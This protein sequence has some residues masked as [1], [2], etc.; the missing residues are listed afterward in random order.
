MMLFLVLAS[1][2][3]VILISGTAYYFWR[4]QKY[5]ENWEHLLNRL[6]TVNRENISAVALD[7][8]DPSG[9]RRT[10]EFAREL[11]PEQ[12]WELL[13]GIEGVEALERNSRVLI[14]IAIYLKKWHPDAAL[15]AE[16]LRLQAREL[17]WQVGK[18]RMAA[19][20]GHLEFHFASYAQNATIG[21]YLM[22]AQLLELYRRSNAPLFVDLDRAI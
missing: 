7:A 8:I 21:Y 19:E 11:K 3:L 9:R 13:G 10:D 12:I 15:L 1:I 14:D 16:E 22:R 2:V 4:A 17:E 6:V 5:K 20:K 18:L